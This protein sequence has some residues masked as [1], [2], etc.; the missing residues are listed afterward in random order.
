MR[1]NATCLGSFV[2]HLR[3]VVFLRIYYKVVIDELAVYYRYQFVVL[4][5]RS[6]DLLPVFS[7]LGQFSGTSTTI[8]IAANVFR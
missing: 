3:A 4:Q 5:I 6:R 7:G 8:H 2:R 1:R